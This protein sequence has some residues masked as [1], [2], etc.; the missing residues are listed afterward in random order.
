MTILES[1]GVTP[2]IEN[3]LRWLGHVERR[4]VNSVVRIVNLM[5]RSQTA[6]VRGRLRKTLREVIK[7]DLEINNLD[8]NM[9]LIEH[10]HRS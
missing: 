4:L 10:Y 3:R 6:R 5:E 7:I 2:I 1:V 9:V 8:R